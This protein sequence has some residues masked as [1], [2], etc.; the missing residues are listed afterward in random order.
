MGLE[1]FKLALSAA[2]GGIAGR[3]T[4]RR[5]ERDAA[6]KT[7]TDLIQ[8][9]ADAAEK[10]WCQPDS[11][12]LERRARK[13]KIKVKR[14]ASLNARIVRRFPTYRFGGVPN[15]MAFRQAA[16]GGQFDSAGRAA[17][18]ERIEKI[19]VAANDLTDAVEDS[20]CAFWQVPIRRW[21]LAFRQVFLWNDSDAG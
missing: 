14:V 9:V 2:A 12:E 3:F 10:Y 5:A 19:H 4:S 16:T 17:D 18:L 6:I 13:L 20:R 1:L 8:E 11:P 7:L 15:L 21:P